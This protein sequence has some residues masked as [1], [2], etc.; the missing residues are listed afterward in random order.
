MRAAKSTTRYLEHLLSDVPPKW[1]PGGIQLEEQEEEQE[2]EGGGSD[3]GAAGH[4]LVDTPPRPS[5]LQNMAVQRAVFGQ[6]WRTTA[7]LQLQ[8]EPKCLPCRRQCRK[9]AQCAVL[10]SGPRAKH[11]M[12][13]KSEKP[14]LASSST[15][16]HTYIHTPTHTHTHTHTQKRRR[17]SSADA[18]TSR[19]ADDA[20]R[21]SL[22]CQPAADV[23]AVRDDICQDMMWR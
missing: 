23:E 2:E 11:A 4:G 3:Q 7:R 19:P 10:D 20:R 9:R 1:A 8:V 17:Q 15:H 14:P 22:Q 6:V 16:T 12:P 5:N 13:H 18:G 21:A